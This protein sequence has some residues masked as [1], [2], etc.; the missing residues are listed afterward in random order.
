MEQARL[1]GGMLGAI[2]Q[3]HPTDTVDLLGHSAGGVV[4]RLA[5]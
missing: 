1:L 5:W 3:R 4:A 2:A